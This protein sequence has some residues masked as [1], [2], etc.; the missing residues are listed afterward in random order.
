[1]IG[2]NYDLTIDYIIPIYYGGENKLS[3]LQTLC[4]KCNSWKSTK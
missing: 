3:N 1:M 4:K 2:K